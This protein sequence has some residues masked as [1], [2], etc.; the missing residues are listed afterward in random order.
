MKILYIEDKR[1]YIENVKKILSSTYLV[2]IA[3]TGHE[4]IE[5]AR[6]VQYSLILLDL[7]LPDMPGLTVCKELRRINIAVPLLALSTQKDFE[8]SV[9]LLNS[10]A[11]DY[12]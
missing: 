9:I 3:R 10:G 7:D 6:S 12:M 8:T 2:D 11:D 4:G 5:S 1:P